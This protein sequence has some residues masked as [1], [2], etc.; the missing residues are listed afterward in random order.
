MEEQ[1]ANLDRNRCVKGEKGQSLLLL[2]LRHTKRRQRRTILLQRRNLHLVSQVKLD[3]GRSGGSSEGKDEAFDVGTVGCGG[4]TGGRQLCGGMRRERVER[5][6]HLS[7][8]RRRPNRERLSTCSRTRLRRRATFGTERQREDDKQRFRT[9]QRGA[10]QRWRV[11]KGARPPPRS[12][13]LPV[14]LAQDERGETDL[15]V[16]IEGLLLCNLVPR[17]LS[18]C[19]FAVG[20]QGR[21]VSEVE[22]CWRMRGRRG[23]HSSGTVEGSAACPL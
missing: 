17:R 18:R 15:C 5:G 4:R 13:P 14:P 16:L 23:A 21:E 1:P 20:G 2:R 7:P 22:P 11:K 10:P 12:L 9:L 6:V 3:R 8:L 19:Q